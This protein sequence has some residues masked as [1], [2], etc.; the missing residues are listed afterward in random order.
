MTAY[1]NT[2]NDKSYTHSAQ[3]GCNGDDTIFATL[4]DLKRINY[5]YGQML[6]VA[7]FQTEQHYFREKLKLHNRCL[8]GY[9]VVCGLKVVP[10]PYEESCIPK[11]DE[12]LKELLT[13]SKELELKRKEL[14]AK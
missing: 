7:D 8:H 11:G 12:E 2:K 14:K 1:S 5:F 9:G 10:E 6:G 4:P 13:Q 3:P